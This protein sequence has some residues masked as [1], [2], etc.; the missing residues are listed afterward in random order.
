LTV[1]PSDT[2]ATCDHGNKF[3]RHRQV[4]S[5][6]SYVLVEQVRLQAMLLVHNTRGFRV[7]HPLEP[8]GLMRIE[9][10]HSL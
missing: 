1:G 6:T 9:Q 4:E 10:P 7:L 2:A 8:A 5:L 3:E